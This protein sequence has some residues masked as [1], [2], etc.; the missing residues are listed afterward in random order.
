MSPFTEGTLVGGGS[1]NVPRKKPR[2]DQPEE[3]DNVAKQKFQ[4][5]KRIMKKLHKKR[6]RWDPFED[7]NGKDSPYLR[8][9]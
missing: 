8:K 7:Q 5:A 2:S 1:F 6:G 3:H 9:G 4:R